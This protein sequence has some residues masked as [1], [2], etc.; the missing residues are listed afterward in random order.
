MI[1]TLEAFLIYLVLSTNSINMSCLQRR[2]GVRVVGLR[3]MRGVV[4]AGAGQ[5]TSRRAPR[6]AEQHRPSSDV[7]EQPDCLAMSQ[8]CGTAAIHG[9]NLVTWKVDKK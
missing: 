9:D 6:H 7:L 5:S 4:A 1:L 8:P 3:L 2:I